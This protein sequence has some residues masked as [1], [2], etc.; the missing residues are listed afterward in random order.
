MKGVLSGMECHNSHNLVEYYGIRH[1]EYEII[2]RFLE[3]FLRL[4]RSHPDLT[5]L[6]DVKFVRGLTVT[7]TT[8]Y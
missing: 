1:E 7:T 2:S 8:M 6:S 3:Q 5:S 4:R